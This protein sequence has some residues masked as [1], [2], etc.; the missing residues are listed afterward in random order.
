ML[1]TILLL[2]EYI[3]LLIL[4]NVFIN[5]LE[6]TNSL[7]SCLQYCWYTHFVK[8]L[9][10]SYHKWPRIPHGEEISGKRFV[11]SKLL[12]CS[13]EWWLRGDTNVI[14]NECTLWFSFL[15]SSKECIW[16]QPM[17]VVFTRPTHVGIPINFWWLWF[18]WNWIWH[19]IDCICNIYAARELDIS[20]S[21]RETWGKHDHQE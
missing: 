18:W 9:I 17:H 5:L 3:M 21:L 13:N 6:I 7:H 12:I 19:P 15:D 16:G 11:K 8:V 20:F 2:L 4:L 1:H 10:G 14:F